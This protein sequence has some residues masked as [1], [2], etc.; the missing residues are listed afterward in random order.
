MAAL[1]I[2]DSDGVV[3]G[4]PAGDDYY[5]ARGKIL[6]QKGWN[7]VEVKLQSLRAVSDGRD[8]A[9]EHI[10]RLVISADRAR[11]PWTFYLDNLLGYSEGTFQALSALAF[12]AAFLTLVRI[13]LA[14]IF[15]AS[16]LAVVTTGLILNALLLSVAVLL[17]ALGLLG[18]YV[19][20]IHNR[21][22]W[23]P[24]YIVREVLAARPA[25]PS[26]AP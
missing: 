16:V 15:P 14:W 9:L 25:A 12:G 10:R 17:G 20:R 13:A 6:V 8:L 18:E 7:H 23:G 11:L 26:P 21:D 22:S 3:N 2:Y 24:R 5:E 19:I 4:G 1:R